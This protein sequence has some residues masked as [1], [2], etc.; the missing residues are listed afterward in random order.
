MSAASGHGRMSRAVLDGPGDPQ[1]AVGKDSP[2]RAGCESSGAPA[3]VARPLT[4]WACHPCCGPCRL[5]VPALVKP[6]GEVLLKEGL[7]TAS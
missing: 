4:R 2:A 1:Q 7:F 3:S 6:G 5:S